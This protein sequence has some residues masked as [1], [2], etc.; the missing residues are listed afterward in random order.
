MIDVSGLARQDT[1]TFRATYRPKHEYPIDLNMRTP[2]DLSMQLT[3]NM[4]HWAQNYA[5]RAPQP[6]SGHKKRLRTMKTSYTSNEYSLQ[7][8]QPHR[9]ENAPK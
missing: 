2:I 6:H 5:E 4:F 8:I 7:D 3:E 9:Q 1:I